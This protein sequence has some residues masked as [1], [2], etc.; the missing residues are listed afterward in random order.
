MWKKL[1][2]RVQTKV[3]GIGF[4]PFLGILLLK[5]NEALLMAL[6]ERWTPITHTFHLP[7]EE[8]GLTPTDF[9]MMTR[10]SMGGDPPPYE[11]KPL[12]TGLGSA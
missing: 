10:L 1:C 12:M 3:L 7:M 5:V 6:A 8:I 2:K 11:A 9:Y 4:G